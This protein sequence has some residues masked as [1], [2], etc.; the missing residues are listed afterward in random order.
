LLVVEIEMDAREP[1]A[2]TEFRSR[3]FRSE[4]GWLEDGIEGV[5]RG[6]VLQTGVVVGGPPGGRPANTYL[7]V[8][9][10]IDAEILKDAAHGRCG[11]Q[12]AVAKG[13]DALARGTGAGGAKSK[14]RIHLLRPNRRRRKRTEDKGGYQY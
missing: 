2:C 14:V 9:E 12:Y 11:I 7:S 4:F 8:D 5:E 13:I 3:A 6:A 1:Y 10:D